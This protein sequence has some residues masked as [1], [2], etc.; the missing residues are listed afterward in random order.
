M[1]DELNRFI[2]CLHG[3]SVTFTGFEIH[4]NVIF[5]FVFTQE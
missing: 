4:T 5:L 2:W 1:L 3:Y